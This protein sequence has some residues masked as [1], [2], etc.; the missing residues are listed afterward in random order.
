[1][2]L[3]DLKLRLHRFRNRKLATILTYHSVVD[4][5]LP[6]GM[7]THLPLRQFADQMALLAQEAQV[8]S[9]R[10]MARGIAAGTLPRYAVAVTFDDGFR[11][12]FTRAYPVLQKYRIP[13]TIFLSTGYIDGTELFWPERLAY[14]LMRTPRQSLSTSL[15]GHLELQTTAE[16]KTAFGTIR[17]ALKTLHPRELQK[18]IA[19]LEEC[20][21]VERREGDPLVQ[22]WLPLSWEDVRAMEA[23]GLVSFG[24]HTVS[25]AILSRLD[26]AEALQEISG[27][28]TALDHH[29]DHRTA[30]WAHPNGTRQDFG[31]RHLEMLAAHAFTTVLTAEPGYVS[32]RS[33]LAM[34]PRMGVHNRMD[35]RGLMR[36]L[37]NRQ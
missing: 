12:N 15:F 16:R 27:C 37:A 17:T 14:Q 33:E 32:C 35:S 30:C 29:L 11:N 1:M 4:L 10:E 26:A 7:W 25:H 31:R 23:D 13:A 34:L 20:L 3:S 6:F 19:D 2:D 9:L 24:G 21:G 8:I 22:E 28:R 36:V 5:P 18:K